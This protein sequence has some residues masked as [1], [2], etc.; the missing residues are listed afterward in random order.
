MSAF[1]TPN[2]R[3]VTLVEGLADASGALALSLVWETPQRIVIDAK[4]WAKASPIRREFLLWHEEKHADFVRRYGM[5]KKAGY[6]NMVLD[7]THR[8][9]PFLQEGAWRLVRWIRNRVDL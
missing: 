7:L 5:T 3:A 9:V 2:G 6:R 4:W 8:T 1:V